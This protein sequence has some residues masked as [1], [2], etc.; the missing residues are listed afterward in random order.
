MQVLFDPATRDFGP[1]GPFADLDR[2]MVDAVDVLA[3]TALISPMSAR[4]A[5]SDIATGQKEVRGAEQR[6][7]RAV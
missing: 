6:Y 7:L 2:E 5:K 4:A 1:G 3:A